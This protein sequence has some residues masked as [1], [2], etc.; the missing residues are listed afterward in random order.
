VEPVKKPALC[1]VIWRDAYEQSTAA[2]RAQTAGEADHT[3]RYSAGWL[4]VDNDA[5]IVLA[6]TFDPPEAGDESGGE[7]DTRLTIP[8][9]YIVSVRYV[10]RGPRKPKE[11]KSD[12]TK[13]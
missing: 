8:R 3:E 1:E 5:K 7:F 4:V 13:A 11:A 6:L 9:S 12:E 10:E 2:T